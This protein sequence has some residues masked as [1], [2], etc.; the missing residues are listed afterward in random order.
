MKNLYNLLCKARSI[1]PSLQ[2][3]GYNFA[4]CPPAD[5]SLK[6]MGTNHLSLVAECGW[7]IYLCQGS[8]PGLSLRQPDQPHAAH[9]AF[10]ACTAPWCWFSCQQV[11]SITYLNKLSLGL[12]LVGWFL[13]CVG[14]C[15]R[16]M[17]CFLNATTWDSKGMAA[18][19]AW[20]QLTVFA[21]LASR[22]PWSI[23]SGDFF[24]GI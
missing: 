15:D 17:W 3:P 5:Y 20:L 9:A 8:D 11:R 16:K 1:F 4:C 6:L 21:G 14:V 2:V 10:H 19:S 23:W 13:W 18:P 12:Y 22:L 7:E 24:R